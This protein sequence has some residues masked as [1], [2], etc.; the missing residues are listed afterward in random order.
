[1]GSPQTLRTVVTA[2]VALTFLSTGVATA[3]PGFTMPSG[4]VTCAV[5]PGQGGRALYCTAP[6]ITAKSYDGIGIVRLGARGRARIEGSGNDIILSIGGLNPGG[7]RDARPILHYGTRF[8]AAGF[9]CVSR[10]SGVD[11]RRSRHGF[12]LSRARQRYY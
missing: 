3:G 1:M 6:Y 12:V 2:A 10:M 4:L 5:L 7:S 11:C 8:A 9:T